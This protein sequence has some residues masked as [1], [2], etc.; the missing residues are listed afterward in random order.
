MCADHPACF[1]LDS[2]LE[3]SE[4]RK[5]TCK[6][7]KMVLTSM[8]FLGL[9]FRETTEVWNIHVPFKVIHLHI[10]E[11]QVACSKYIKPLTF[12]LNYLQEISNIKIGIDNLSR[13]NCHVKIDI[14]CDVSL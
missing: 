3:W 10:I 9:P 14:D 8:S 5:E 11:F 2:D 6:D 4:G 1:E 13:L 12:V 7:T